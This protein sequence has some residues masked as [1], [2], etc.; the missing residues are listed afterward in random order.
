MG[1]ATNIARDPVVTPASTLQINQS[2]LLQPRK[3]TYNRGVKDSI[4]FDIL[5]FGLLGIEFWLP[6][7]CTILEFSKNVGH[8]TI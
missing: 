4:R 2:F 1:W 3:Y 5:E 7:S 8:F 6:F